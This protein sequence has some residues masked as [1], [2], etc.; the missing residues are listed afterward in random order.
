MAQFATAAATQ[1]DVVIDMNEGLLALARRA[2]DP[3]DVAA[4][5]RQVAALLV[6]VA[7]AARTDVTVHF[8]ADGIALPVA[9]S[10]LSPN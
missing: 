3:A 5:L 6:P 10:Y 9:G 2:R 1:L 8:T 7:A 4:A